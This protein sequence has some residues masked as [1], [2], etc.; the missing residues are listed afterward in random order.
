MTN[1]PILDRLELKGILP[2]NFLHGFASAAYQ[3][4]G[5]TSKDGR[6]PCSW[7][8]FLKDF[9]DKGDDACRSYDL[10]EEDVKLLKQF[11]AKS[12]RFSISWS[13]VKPKGGASDPANEAGIQYHP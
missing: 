11:G 1:K 13:R 6:G 5:A 3:V 7:D 10:W 2:S 4:E 9:P 12:Y 8:D